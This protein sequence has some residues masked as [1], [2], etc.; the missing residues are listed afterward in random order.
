MRIAVFDLD[1]TLTRHDTLWPYLR[2]WTR[3]HPR[4]RF[5]PV[6]IAAA[7]R[8]PFDRDRGRLKADLIRAAM[9][10]ASRAAVA[11][12]TAEYVAGLGDAELCPGALAQVTRHAAAGDRLVL[13]SASVDLYVPEIGCRFGFHEAICTAIAWQADRLDGALASPN[14]RG[15]EKRRCVESL[16]AR[17]PGAAV[18]AYGNAASDFA[19]FEAADEA[20]LVNAGRGLRRRAK[21]CG[22]RTAEWRNN[23]PVS[24]VR[25]A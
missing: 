14:R 25:Q 6:T 5:W 20:V 23:R 16:R 3:R 21:S 10:G 13:L 24:P 7:V 8:Y 4:L 15:E 17:Y 19:H 1:G 12:W 2:G 22:F 11:A 9:A 18:T